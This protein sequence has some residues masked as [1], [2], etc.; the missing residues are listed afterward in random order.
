MRIVVNGEFKTTGAKTLAELCL[1]LG[2][3]EARVATAING[4]FV[5]APER[6]RVHIAEGDAIEIVA[7]RQGG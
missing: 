4:A 1:A 6:E 7:P 3:A 5:P 2:L